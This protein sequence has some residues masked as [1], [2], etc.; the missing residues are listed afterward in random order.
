VGK[1]TKYAIGI[2]YG[3]ESGRVV[4]VDI[5]TG[6]EVATH[7][8][9]Y[10]D[11]VIDEYL[12]QTE[13][14]LEQE[15]A[16]QNPDDYLLVLKQSVPEVLKT[17]GVPADDIVG[18][19]IDFTSC[20]MVPVDKNLDPLCRQAVWKNN[21]HSWVKLWKH[22][23]AQDK[24][25]MLNQIAEKRGEPWLKNYGGKV[26]SEWMLP[27]I[28]EVLESSPDIYEE[29]DLFLEAVDWVIAKM[30]GEVKRNSCSAGYKDMWHKQNGYV[31]SDFLQALDPRLKD[32]YQTK[33]RGEVVS[34]GAKAGN[35]S[36][37]MAEL[38]GLNPGTAVAV[39]I[40]DAHAGVPG[41]GV[42][43]PGK[44]VMV[45][46][47]STCHLLLSDEEVH[48]EGVSG[49][50]EDGIIPGYFA[51]EAGQAAVGDI[52]AWFVN[53]CVPAYI[54]DEAKKAGVSVHTLLEQ[55]AS[56]LKPG[57]SGLLALDWHN[58]NRTPLVDAG[59]SGIIIGQTL[60]T[61]PE[62]IYRALI[63]ATA[64]GTQLIIDTFRN[65]GVEVKELYACGGLPHRNHL[66]MQIYAD[67]TNME[68]KVSSS[69][70]TPAVGSAMFGAVAAGSQ[71]GG[72]D[73][74]LEASEKM[75]KLQ[76]K[77]FKPNEEH[78]KIYR[79]LYAEYAKLQNYF[80]RGENDVMKRLKEIK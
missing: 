10:S 61:K 70:I 80:G 26:S 54:N 24:A 37:E 79:K 67:V 12:P 48:V 62:E 16:L 22:H 31:S 45:M 11:G 36:A 51:Y 58:G 72:Y 23:A 64:F 4:L 40:I 60:L 52:F 14:K 34:I 43:T 28:W 57:E 18:I 25:T 17:S 46:G 35:L 65:K 50:V 56:K 21:P 59:L 3:T 42:T 73:S 71:Q 63:E 30:T 6:E 9:P 77:T 68:I 38:M 47:T 74:I 32:I 8:T 76:E 5:N 41:V 66:L 20:T 49:V 2:D 1:T 69:T 7:V 15:F 27:K 39:G 33:L 75:S 19:G 13:I 78:V 53:Q 44:M 29:V 55:K